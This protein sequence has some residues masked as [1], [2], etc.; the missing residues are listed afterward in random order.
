M[1]LFANILSSV[2][3]GSAVWLGFG[4]WNHNSTE[5][6]WAAAL[7]VLTVTIR[8]IVLEEEGE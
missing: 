3:G 2:I 7:L 8:L 1:K 4:L 5:Y 6:G